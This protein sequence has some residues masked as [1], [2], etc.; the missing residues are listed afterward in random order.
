[1][2]APEYR[3][4]PVAPTL[5]L[6]LVP[7]LSLLTVPLAAQAVAGSRTSLEDAVSIVTVSEGEEAASFAE[8]L[9]T[10]L[11]AEF[12]SAG[13]LASRAPS[14]EKPSGEKPS[15]SGTDDGAIAG[16]VTDGVLASLVFDSGVR[17]AAIVRC[18][19]DKKRLV[20]RLSVY[21]G[22]DGALVASDARSAFAGL[23]VMPEL[24]ASATSVAENVLALKDRAM[25][26]AFID[27]RLR[28]FSP[29]EGAQ[30]WFGSGPDARLA[31]SI[32]DGELLAPFVAFVAEQESILQITLDE[33]WPRVIEIKPGTTD[34]PVALKPLM[35][36]AR[37]ALSI[38]LGA[39][40][41]VGFS[42][43]YRFHIFEDAL[44]VRAGNHFWAQ[45]DDSTDALPV[46]HDE[47]RL[48]LG[49]YLL[50]PRDSRLRVAA[51][52]GVSGIASM[53]FP[54]DLAQKLYFDVT[55]DLASFLFEWHWPR[56]AFFLE[57]R[58]GYGV[59]M[60]SGLRR[61]GWIDS[62]TGLLMLSAGV[63]FKWP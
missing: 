63:M 48:G 41:P 22:I 16:D 31:G 8:A 61:A 26:G 46:L 20:W 2:R 30:L 44:F 15:G 35:L 45:G 49:A 37:H 59:G 14:S 17:W 38:G 34:L 3:R 27:Y 11:G 7:L 24:E 19:V 10:A 54:E 25:P 42:L 51:G 18:S 1:M 13:V 40:R 53:M 43:E 33:H 4:V 60:E 47:L 56:V 52:T 29:D 28:F 58:I 12:S 36:K 39:S 50:R 23:S 62:G 57:E 5:V 9:V 6:A 21:D 32:T 55:L